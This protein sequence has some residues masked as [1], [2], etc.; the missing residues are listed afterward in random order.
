MS[1]HSTTL[2][3]SVGLASCGMQ[4]CTNSYLFSFYT[5]GSIGLLAPCVC[6]LTT[7]LLRSIV[8]A[9]YCKFLFPLFLVAVLSLSSLHS[10]GAAGHITPETLHMGQNARLNPF[11]FIPYAPYKAKYCYCT[12]LLLM[13]HFVLLL[14]LQYKPSRNSSRK[15][16]AYSMGLDQWCGL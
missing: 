13:L 16:D 10:L 4:K 7:I 5:V 15:W 2:T 9:V 14:V 1:F 3:L 12:G 8:L 11:R 6:K